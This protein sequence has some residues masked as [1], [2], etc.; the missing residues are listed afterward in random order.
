MRKLVLIGVAC[1]VVGL[2]LGILIGR[3][4]M[5]REWSQPAVLQRV[6]A[7]DAARSTGKDADPTPKVGSLLLGPAPLARAR[8]VL[9]ELVKS[10]P[11]VAGVADVADVVDGNVLNVDFLNRGKCNVTAFSGTAYGYDAY[12]KPSAMNKGGEYYVAFS[13]DNIS[14]FAPNHAHSLAMPLH[15]VDIAS[16]A[17]AQVNEVTCSDGSKWARN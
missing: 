16:M 4:M 1:L 12:G 15:N 11:V 13:A 2:L 10:D 9:T 7:A 6:S 17:I 3:A 14:D 5:E 8:M